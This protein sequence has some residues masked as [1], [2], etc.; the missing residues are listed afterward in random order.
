MASFNV[1]FFVCDRSVCVRKDG[2]FLLLDNP[3]EVLCKWLVEN[4]DESGRPIT[5]ERDFK[6]VVLFQSSVKKQCLMIQNIFEDLIASY[7]GTTEGLKQVLLQR[8]QEKKQ[9]LMDCGSRGSAG[10]L[11]RVLRELQEEEI[12]EKRCKEIN[13]AKQSGQDNIRV[14]FQAHVERTSSQPGEASSQINLQKLENLALLAGMASVL[15]PKS[16]NKFEAVGGEN[17][18]FLESPLKFKDQRQKLA[19]P[20][21]RHQLIPK[22]LFPT[23]EM[24]ASHNEVTPTR[25]CKRDHKMAPNLLTP[26]GFLAH[27]SQSHSLAYSEFPSTA[28]FTDVNVNHTPCHADPFPSNERGGLDTDM[29]QLVKDS[30]DPLRFRNVLVPMRE[31]HK[32]LEGAKAARDSAGFV[33]N[34]V[35]EILFSP[36]ELAS[37]KGISKAR[38]GEAALDEEKVDALFEGNRLCARGSEKRAG[39]KGYPEEVVCIPGTVR[40]VQATIQRVHRIQC[41]YEKSTST[42]IQ[43]CSF[44]P[45]TI[46][47]RARPGAAPGCCSSEHYSRFSPSPLSIKQFLDFG[48]AEHNAHISMVASRN[49]WSRGA[50]PC[51]TNPL[52]AGFRCSKHIKDKKLGNKTQKCNGRANMYNR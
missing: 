42:L 49:T 37:A 52:A 16:T 35:S 8:A 36:K 39:P 20:S 47:I 7:S 15:H 40:A 31:F 21:P 29:Q 28:T 3:G 11:K 51:R 46:A 44:N 1:L 18:T 22:K 43:C 30:N 24:T 5:E 19:F 14:A 4:I 13:K 23:Q 26:Q 33:L 9:L 25:P 38:A 32:V 48:T 2:E 50:T 27:S 6:A 41:Y 45:L 10:R 17:E 34:G 12:A